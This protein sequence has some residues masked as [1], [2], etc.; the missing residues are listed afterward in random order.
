MDSLVLL[1]LRYR[2]TTLSRMLPVGLL[3]HR[4][5]QLAAVLLRAFCCFC[6]LSD[7]PLVWGQ[8]LG[9]RVLPLLKMSYAYAKLVRNLCGLRIQPNL[10][11]DDVLDWSMVV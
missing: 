5:D 11:S 10:S 9:F 6:W 8:L 2:G 3:L 4:L 7:S 1:L